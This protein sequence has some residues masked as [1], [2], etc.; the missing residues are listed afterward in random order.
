ML[1]I[2]AFKR[3]SYLEQLGT[4]V[5]VL[6]WSNKGLP[7]CLTAFCFLPRHKQSDSLP[8]SSI[9]QQCAR[10]LLPNSLVHFTGLCSLVTKCKSLHVW[11]A[12]AKSGGL[13]E[14]PLRHIVDYVR[15]LYDTLC[16]GW[17]NVYQWTGD[18]RL[19]DQSMSGLA[20]V[21]RKKPE[22]QLKADYS[23]MTS[24]PDLWLLS[25]LFAKLRLWF[26]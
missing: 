1:T 18:K 10:M 12:V 14:R 23:V 25:A 21:S 11:R 20:P 16:P 9:F 26:F 15:D 24:T 17:V 19:M 3:T 2:L 6:S 13:C 7:A 22:Q 4:L 8:R 5:Q